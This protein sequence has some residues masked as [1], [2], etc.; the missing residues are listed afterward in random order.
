MAST[1][2]PTLQ[3]LLSLDQFRGY[4]VLGM[5]LVNFVGSFAAIPAVLKH[6]NNY[7]SYADTIMPQFLFAVG[8]AFRLTF[9]RR[10]Q[11]E[12]AGAAYGRVIQRLFGLAL[13][14]I[15]VYGTSAPAET[16]SQLVEMGPMAAL[17]PSLKR[18][19]FQTLMHIA[20]TSLWVLPVIRAGHGVRIGY[21]L[22]SAILHVFLSWQFNFEWC[23][24]SPNAI[25]GGPLAFLTWSIPAILG[26]L[27]CD[28]V[29][30]ETQQTP[31]LRLGIVSF[32]LMAV[33]WGFSCGTRF[34]DVPVEKVEQL[35]EQRLAENPVL[36]A[37]DQLAF[38][39][40]A[41][42]P[43]VQ[44]PDEK[45]RKWNYW[46]MSQRAGTLSYLTF[47]AGFSL[48]VYMGFHF[49]CDKLHWQLGLFRLFGTNALI[50]YIL[51][52]MVMGAIK[53]F[54]PKDSPFWYVAV[55][56]LLVL[57]ILWLFIRYLERNK[58]FLRL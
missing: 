40:F 18:N 5:V 37:G 26:T 19:W 15:V 13:V 30:T 9:D 25:D 32:A 55:A 23:N 56:W 43:F 36:P 33:G 28:W 4:T 6:H 42:L 52:S 11:R 34:Y 57:S 14:S 46:M 29:N 10:V 21:A 17:G 24:T 31:W 20:A 1:T 54:V 45:E 22:L 2:Q 8:F 48:L 16:W 3:R 50:A 41:E 53:P 49:L 35:K 51:H 58:V 38:R 47:S 7:C 44:P 12:G 39:G 27:A